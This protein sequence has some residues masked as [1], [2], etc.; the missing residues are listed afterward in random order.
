MGQ[1]RG[2]ILVSAAC[3]GNEEIGILGCCVGVQAG[4]GK[5]RDAWWDFERAAL[6]LYLRP[7]LIKSV[8]TKVEWRH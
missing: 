3:D 4:S 7:F 8:V 5:R 2:R 6:N 1:P